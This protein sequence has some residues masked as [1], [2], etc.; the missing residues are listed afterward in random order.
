MFLDRQISKLRHELWLAR[1]S[2][3]LG[4]PGQIERLEA[5][6]TALSRELAEAK[7]ENMATLKRHGERMSQGAT[8]TVPVSGLGDVRCEHCG[9]HSQGKRVCGF[10]Q[11]TQ[12]D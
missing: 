7:L 9:Q 1:E 4:I 2:E 12:Q 10:C 5:Q 3:K 11:A 6:L 8:P